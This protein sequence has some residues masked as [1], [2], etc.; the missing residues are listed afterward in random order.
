MRKITRLSTLTEGF[1]GYK[2]L[3]HMGLQPTNDKPKRVTLSPPLSS[4]VVIAY[5]IIRM[6]L[7]VRTYSTI[8]TKS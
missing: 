1:K 3:A 6:L 7:I 4:N 2:A 8:H 5:K